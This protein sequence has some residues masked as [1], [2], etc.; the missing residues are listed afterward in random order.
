[1]NS[2]MTVDVAAR[3]AVEN[4]LDAISKTIEQPPD[5]E[6]LKRRVPQANGDQDTW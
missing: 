3:E 6:D 2:A 5:L 4:E 1:M